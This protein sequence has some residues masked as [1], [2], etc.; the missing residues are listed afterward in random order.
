MKITIVH[1]GGERKQVELEGF[2][3]PFWAQVRYPN[4][5]GCYLFHCEHGRI[6]AK[7]SEQPRWRL[8][9]KDR[10]ALEQMARAEK[11]K[12]RKASAPGRPKTPGKKPPSKQTEM[13]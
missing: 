2:I 3:R 7:R 1:D 10:I 9:E 5:G 13:F 6:E 11:M 8:L 4:G 12:P